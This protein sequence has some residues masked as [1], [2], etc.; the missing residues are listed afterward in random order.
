MF[1]KIKIA[2][3]FAVVAAAGSIFA[4]QYWQ[5]NK[6]KE[7]VN[8]LTENNAK[9]E[10]AVTQQQEVISEFE[11][12]LSETIANSNL[13][14]E[15][16]VSTNERHQKIV[17]ELNSYRGRLERVALEKPEIVEDRINRATAVIMQQFAA[18]TGNKEQSGTD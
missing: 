1:L 6:M 10:V 4:Y 5:I 3:F 2:I 11:T 16:I 12:E 18:E 8:I 13:L 7:T 9:L 15:E 14:A 17:Q